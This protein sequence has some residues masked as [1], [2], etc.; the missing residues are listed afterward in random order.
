MSSVLKH[1]KITEMTVNLPAVA[2]KVSWKRKASG[3]MKKLKKFLQKQFNV[4]G[5]VVM[6]PELN[7]FVWKGGIEKVPRRIRIRVERCTSKKN[8]EKSAL[9]VSLVLVGSFKGLNSESF[10]E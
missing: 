9:R 8:V 6:S 4:E 10:N 2:R 5:E 1:N 7:K 3:A